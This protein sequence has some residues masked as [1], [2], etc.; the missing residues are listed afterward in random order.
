MTESNRIYVVVNSMTK[1]S[2]KC[3]TREQAE[4]LVDHLNGIGEGPDEGPW[5]IV[6]IDIDDDHVVWGHA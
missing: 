3:D 5:R 4:E 6:V 1:D 2:R